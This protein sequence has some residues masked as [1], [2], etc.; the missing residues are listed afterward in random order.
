[1][2]CESIG[3]FSCASASARVHFFSPPQPLPRRVWPLVAAEAQEI[4][5]PSERRP[6]SLSYGISLRTRFHMQ[7]PASERPESEA[8][9]FHASNPPPTHRQGRA[10][11]FAA[12]E[13][14]ETPLQ[15]QVKTSP[16][17]L[18]AKSNE[19]LFLH[20]LAPFAELWSLPA[21][22]PPRVLTT[23]TSI[24]VVVFH[25]NPNG[26]GRHIALKRA[27]WT[28]ATRP[29]E[30]DTLQLLLPS[31]TSLESR[32]SQNFPESTAQAALCS[33]FFWTWHSYRVSGK[34]C[35]S[36]GMTMT[37]DV[38]RCMEDCQ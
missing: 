14:Q 12:A 30:L 32:V 22:L 5:V 17:L 1:M 36:L 19:M 38:E 13:A 25:A 20:P 23:A 26:A 31:L 29:H 34:S 6:S 18:G 37:C 8:L 10:R 15:L 7:L 24:S 21:L 2:F 4:P 9:L 16:T 28:P 27:K 11:P 33:S 3:V 35:K